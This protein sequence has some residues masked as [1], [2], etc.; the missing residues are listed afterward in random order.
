MQSN[1]QLR[2]E[3]SVDCRQADYRPEVKGC[4][5]A[6]CKRVI[7]DGLFTKTEVER[8]AQFLLK[9][10]PYGRGSGGPTILDV[11]QGTLSYGE[12]FIDV[13]SKL[14]A[15]GEQPLST[16]RPFAPSY[17]LPARRTMS[18]LCAR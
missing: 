17:S 10:L 5:P 3:F 16:A 14:K 6:S 8:L 9:L 13:F 15:L 12:K 4:S 11:H 7:R 1:L 18:R 2:R